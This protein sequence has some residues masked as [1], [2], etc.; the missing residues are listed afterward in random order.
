MRPCSQIMIRIDAAVTLMVVR[1]LRE[2]VHGTRCSHSPSHVVSP[3]GSGIAPSIVDAL[4][5]RVLMLCPPL[6]PRHVRSAHE[7]RRAQEH[8]QL[9]VERMA[10][11]KNLWTDLNTGTPCRILLDCASQMLHFFQSEG[12]WQACVEQFSQC[13]FPTGSDDSIFL[14][15]KCF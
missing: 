3:C 2:A 8:H 7:G 11:A 15:I 4:F 5:V 14:A 1:Q 12:L 9:S 10:T 13:H 6:E